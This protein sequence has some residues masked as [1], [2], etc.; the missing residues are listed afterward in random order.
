LASPY[1]EAS[2]G[3]DTALFP[4][5]NYPDVPFPFLQVELQQLLAG[6]ILDHLTIC[7]LFPFLFPV[8]CGQAALL[9]LNSYSEINSYFIINKAS[10]TEQCSLPKTPQ[11]TR[12]QGTNSQ[13]VKNS[14]CKKLLQFCLQEWK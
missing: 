5:I 10:E 6:T 13:L 14:S 8:V 11:E 9:C 12:K 3:C 2:F 1:L 7:S 4:L